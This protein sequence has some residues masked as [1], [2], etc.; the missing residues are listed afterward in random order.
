MGQ[1][2]TGRVGLV[3]AIAVFSCV[4]QS[5]TGAT[6]KVPADFATIQEAVDAALP[7][8]TVLVT[9]GTYAENVTIPTGK[10]GITL[11]GKGKVII[12]ARPGGVDGGVD[13][14]RRPRA[15]GLI[16]AR[17]SGGLPGAQSVGTGSCGG[18]GDVGGRRGGA[19]LSGRA[20]F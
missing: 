3:L 2:F 15:S 19:C 18:G 10:D 8:D 1:G 14:G 11:R 17:L 20:G 6:L 5:A 7:A 12:D 4:A 16:G 9:G 13:V